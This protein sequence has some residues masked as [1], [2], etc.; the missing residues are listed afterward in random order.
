[1]IGQSHLETQ[2]QNSFDN[3]GKMNPKFYTKNTPRLNQIY[4]KKTRKV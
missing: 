2:M 1:M 3:V 4:P